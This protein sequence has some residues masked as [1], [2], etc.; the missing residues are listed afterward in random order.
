MY[1][2]HDAFNHQHTY[3][4]SADTSRTPSKPAHEH[5]PVTRKP[6][7]SQ[8][9]RTGDEGRRPVRPMSLLRPAIEARA[10]SVR[11]GLCTAYALQGVT[12]HTGDDI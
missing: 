9:P 8:A 12:T 6:A 7:S 5:T 3:L 2:H 4:Y 11:A 1:V 10:R